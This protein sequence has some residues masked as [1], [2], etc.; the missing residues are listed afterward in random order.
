MVEE[1]TLDIHK[2][3]VRVKQMN[4][5]FSFSRSHN[6]GIRRIKVAK[7]LS[8]WIKL[9]FFYAVANELLE[10]AATRTYKQL[11]A[12]HSERDRR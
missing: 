11:I 10:S 3:L 4:A 1:S 7:E 2:G 6:T 9:L 12:P 8:K 5:M